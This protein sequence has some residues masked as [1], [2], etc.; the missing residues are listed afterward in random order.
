MQLR[1][2]LC[3]GTHYVNQSS[4]KL[5]DLPVL[6]SQML[7]LKMS[8]HLHS[9][10]SSEGCPTPQSYKAS[11]V[12]VHPSRSV[13]ETLLRT[14]L[15]SQYPK[16]TVPISTGKRLS[17]HDPIPNGSQCLSLRGVKRRGQGN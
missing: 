8:S 4:I 1:N 5:R 6:A 3:P 7:G 15:S 16:N 10:L 13:Q 9:T 11:R 14:L 12:L 2:W 17:P